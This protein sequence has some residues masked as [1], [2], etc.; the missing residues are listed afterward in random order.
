MAGWVERFLHISDSF[1]VRS[2]FCVQLGFFNGVQN[3]L[4]EWARL[5]PHPN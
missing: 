4:E 3:L 5:E 1:L 2:N